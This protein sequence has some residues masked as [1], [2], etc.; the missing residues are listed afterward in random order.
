M[1]K[2][3]GINRDDAAE[4][5]RDLRKTMGTLQ[6]KKGAVKGASPSGDMKDIAKTI[7]DTISQSMK[8]DASRPLSPAVESFAAAETEDAIT[9]MAITSGRPS[10]NAGH[11]GAVSAVILFAVVKVALSIVDGMGLASATNAQASMQGYSPAVVAQAPRGTPGNFTKEEARILISLDQRRSDLEERSKKLDEREFDIG[12]RDKEFVTKLAQLRDLSETLKLERV[13]G[14]K[15]KNVQLDQLANVYG[16]M[17]PQEA[18]ALMEQLDVTI[19]LSLLERMPEKRIGQILA[20]M[21][22]E[23]ALAMTRMLSGP[24]GAQ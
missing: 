16:S 8:K 23:R 2:K 24:G 17:A 19:A 18:A 3:K 12:R 15:K 4:L 14:E 13:K 9:H 21:N 11:V 10:F 20:L 5:Y 1:S 6:K 22:P 7:A